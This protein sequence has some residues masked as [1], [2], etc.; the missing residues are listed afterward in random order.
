MSP[1]Y[2]IVTPKGTRLTVKARKLKRRSVRYADRPVGF[3]AICV[4]CG[5]VRG[6][7]E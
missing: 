3:P 2:L 4:S 5:A 1:R 6:D 7:Q